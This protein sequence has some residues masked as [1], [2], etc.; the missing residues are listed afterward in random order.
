MTAADPDARLR[1]VSETTRAFAEATTDLGRLL[2]TIADRVA[3]TIGDSCAILMLSEDNARLIPVALADPDPVVLELSRSVLMEPVTLASH[4]VV[5]A[6]VATGEPYLRPVL[7]LEEI[8]PPRTTA[9]YY[10]FV[11][12]I[13]LH[14]MLIVG[15]R[16]RGETIGVLALSRHKTGSAAYGT[17]DVTLSQILAD[18]AALAIANARLYEAERSARTAAQQADL[19]L[20]EAEQSHQRFFDHS[21]LAMLIFDSETQQMLAVNQAALALYGYTLEEFMALRVPD[22]RGPDEATHA[23]TRLAAAGAADLVTTA[24]IRKRDGRVIDVEAWTN[25]AT[26]AGRPAR[27]V[28]VSDLSDR[29]SL[30]EARASEARFRALLEGAPDAVVLVNDRGMIVLVNGQTERLFG[31]S[32]AALI[33]QPVEMLI[34]ERYRE[35]DP[36][37]RGGY[38]ADPRIRTM[39]SDLE[40][41]GLRKDGSEFPVEISLSPV[42][43]ELGGLVI[44][45]IRDV[46][47]REEIRTALLVANR[48]LEAFSYSV[49][50]DLR[51][52]LR[53]MNGFA[54]M[55]LDSSRDRLDEEGLDCL[56]EIL[57][58]SRK[59]GALI[60]ALLAL[61]RMSRTELRAHLGDLSAM[62]RAVARQ[63]ATS[64]P[65]RSLDITIQDGLHATFDARLIEALLVNLLG[66]AWK[67][68]SKV[69]HARI[70][71][72][73]I[74]AN[75]GRSYCIRDNGAGFDMQFAEN[76]FAP[77]QRQHSVH[78]FPGTGVG[79]ATVQ[80]IVHRHGGRIWVEAAPGRGAAFYF[81][82]PGSRTAESS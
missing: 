32:R 81:T 49:A 47:Q 8:R 64:H 9:R 15:L 59:M 16:V 38:F 55:V 11:Q 12:R 25:A 53:A 50:H 43:S 58:N 76:L 73:A 44:S 75:G 78:E 19:E 20:R 33:G 7:D 35:R 26:F 22:L 67:F 56:E 54:Q 42:M 46:T 29:S 80:R 79:L 74:D 34:P 17:S 52:P 21:P 68:T 31:Y 36:E 18:H 37:H 40:L 57:T 82:L 14:S 45:A 63:L 71:F 69:A 77:F 27:Y 3:T 2:E 4:P 13:G 24:R 62:V 6:V 70:E 66:N 51:A 30:R 61:A 10:A 48:E 1:L 60:D 5:Q 28:A 72:L 41:R 39:G 65:D 23:A